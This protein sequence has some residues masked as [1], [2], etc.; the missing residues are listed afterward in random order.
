VSR[1]LRPFLL[2]LLAR[3]GRV[4]QSGLALR[5]A[6]NRRWHHCGD[7]AWKKVDEIKKDFGETGTK[8][9]GRKIMFDCMVE[10]QIAP[11]SVGDR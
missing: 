1:K 11:Y 6:E 10:K 3:N 8:S 9:L 7:D 5:Q 2:L 4:G